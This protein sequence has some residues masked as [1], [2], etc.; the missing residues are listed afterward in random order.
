VSGLRIQ[1]GLLVH[2]PAVD[3]TL[4]PVPVQRH[5]FQ[6]KGL[7][8]IRECQQWGLGQQGLQIIKGLLALLTP[9]K[10][11]ILVCE[12]KQWCSHLRESW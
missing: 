7:G 10:R 11:N 9:L 3:L 1:L 12:G 5:L 4:H 6:H 2:S 8:E